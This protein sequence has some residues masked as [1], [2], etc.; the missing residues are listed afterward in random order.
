MCVII[1]KKV[2]CEEYTGYKLAIKTKDNKIYS[3]VTGI[4]YKEGP[5]PVITQGQKLTCPPWLYLFLWFS[6]STGEAMFKNFYNR[7][8]RGKTFVFRNLKDAKANAGRGDIILKMTIK[9]N[10][11]NAVMNGDYPTVGGN[12]IVSFKEIK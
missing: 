10:L 5:V 1:D 3:V 12:E 2:R 4:L 7:G 9:G 6:S 8:A 11:V